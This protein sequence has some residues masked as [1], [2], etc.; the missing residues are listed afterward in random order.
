MSYRPCR[1]DWSCVTP[2]LLQGPRGWGWKHRKSDHVPFHFSPALHACQ[3]FLKST[4]ADLRS[5][6]SLLTW[7]VVCARLLLECA[8]SLW[9]RYEHIRPA[10]RTELAYKTDCL[11]IVALLRTMAQLVRYPPTPDEKDEQDE[12]EKEDKNDAG[13]L[14][15]DVESNEPRWSIDFA[16]W[17]R[18]LQQ[19]DSVAL[20]FVAAWCAIAAPDTSVP[21]ALSQWSESAQDCKLV[22]DAGGKSI[23]YSNVEAQAD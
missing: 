7:R 18:S 16:S 11:F 6:L 2:F 3:L 5:L 22:L 8:V 19:V 14:T 4:F 12:E 20:K 10:R 23:I 1:S 15:V 17:D 21:V 13:L 9:V